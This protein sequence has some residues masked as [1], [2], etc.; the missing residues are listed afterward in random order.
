MKNK[1]LNFGLVDGRHPLPVEEYIFTGELNPVDVEGIEKMAEQFAVSKKDIEAQV[2]NIY[3]TGL[4]VALISAI[5]AI[6]ANFP[7]AQVV[8][9]HY[10]RDIGQYFDQYL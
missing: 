2:V 9:K 10:N 8:I 5:K 7:N 4:T 3:A 6:N 1:E